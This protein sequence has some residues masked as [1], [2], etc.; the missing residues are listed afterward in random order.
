[1]GSLATGMPGCL[2]TSLFLRSRN[3]RRRGCGKEVGMSGEA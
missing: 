1:M 3:W 2:G